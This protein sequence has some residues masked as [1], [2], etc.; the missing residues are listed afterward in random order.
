MNLSTTLSCCDLVM[1]WKDEEP[2]VRQKAVNMAWIIWGERNLR[3]FE[4]KITPNAVLLARLE[5]VVRE[6]NS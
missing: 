2:E 6:Y 5:R 3:V 1:A 4:V